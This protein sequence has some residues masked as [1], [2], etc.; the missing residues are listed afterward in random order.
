[1]DPINN[2]VKK[3]RNQKNSATKKSA[4]PQ[5]AAPPKIALSTKK[6]A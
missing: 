6:A 4:Q 3:Q 5:I 1:M 2:F